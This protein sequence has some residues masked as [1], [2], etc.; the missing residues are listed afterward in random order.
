MRVLLLTILISIAAACVNPQ[1]DDRGP[2]IDRD[3]VPPLDAPLITDAQLRRY[4]VRCEDA[5]SSPEPVQ[6][7]VGADE[8]RVRELFARGREHFEREE[9]EQAAR[10]MHR[11]YD[12]WP[13]ISLL[14]NAARAEERAGALEEAVTSYRLLLDE[15][16]PDQQLCMRAVDAL[17]RIR[18]ELRALRE[19]DELARP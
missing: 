12:I 13:N 19:E 5:P 4:R 18:G 17:E 6:P 3:A 16:H 8:H 7:L 15:H 11:A 2:L 14:Y 1:P 9:Y 10:A